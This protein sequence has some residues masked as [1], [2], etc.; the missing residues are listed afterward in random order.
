[1]KVVGLEKLENFVLLVSQFIIRLTFY[2][3]FDWLVLFDF[4]RENKKFKAI[5]KVYYR[6][7]D[8]IVKINNYYNFFE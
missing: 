1:M 5:L 4:L 6:V 3:K 2:I 7:D 8:F